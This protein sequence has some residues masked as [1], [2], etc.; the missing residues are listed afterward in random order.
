MTGDRG[1]TRVALT[2]VFGGI[3]N[4]VAQGVRAHPR[5]WLGGAGGGVL[6]LAALLTWV[7]WP[8]QPSPESP[9]ARPYIEYTACL[10]TGEEGI[11][12]PDAAP[13]WAGLQDGSTPARCKTVG[14]DA[15][16][17]KPIRLEELARALQGGK[18]TWH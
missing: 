17:Q 14:A 3:V 8:D 7:L 15:F 12:G 1:R 6:V 2:R 9:R 13:V 11:A 5:R 10:L 16:V 4:S 18:R